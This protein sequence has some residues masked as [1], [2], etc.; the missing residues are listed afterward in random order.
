M[1]RML[2]IGGGI[3][4]GYLCIAL[5]YT[6]IDMK[7]WEP[8]HAHNMFGGW[9]G[10]MLLFCF[11]PVADVYFLFEHGEVKQA[12]FNMIAFLVPMGTLA[13]LVVCYSAGLA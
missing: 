13:Y 10:A 1:K 12:L 11:Y 4:A 6:I 9:T 3:L 7:P 2:V 5:L 8:H